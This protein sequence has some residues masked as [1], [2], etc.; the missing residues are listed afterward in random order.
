MLYIN[1]LKIF[2]LIAHFCKILFLTLSF[3][4]VISF[5]LSILWLFGKIKHPFSNDHHYTA[6][7][8]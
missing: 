3:K 6:I 1:S 5:M 2:E 4:C 8:N 7:C